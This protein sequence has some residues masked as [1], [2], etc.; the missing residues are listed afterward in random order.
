ML[1]SFT[2]ASNSDAGSD[3]SDVQSWKV[4]DN[5]ANAVQLSNNDAGRLSRPVHPLKVLDRDD[6][7]THPSNSDA[8]RLFS[9]EQPLKVLEKDVVLVWLLKRCSG[10]VSSA[11]QFLN[12]LL[13][14]A[15]LTTQASNSPAGIA[16][17]EE[18]SANVLVKVPPLAHAANKPSGSD[19]SAVQPSN[20]DAKLLADT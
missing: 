13:K 18:Q 20:S 15:V 11:V 5:V 6:T 8:G 1:L 19:S 4:A 9:P 14:V 17:R 16:F 12:V 3:C 10:S 2:F 7:L